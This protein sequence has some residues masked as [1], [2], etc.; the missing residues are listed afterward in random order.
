[1][2]GDLKLVGIRPNNEQEWG[3]YPT[4]LMKRALNQKPGLFGVQYSSLEHQ[5]F[6]RHIELLNQYLSDWE[7]EPELTDK[8]YLKRIISNILKGKI[9]SS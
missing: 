2:N 3:K 8:I 4:S 5:G 7:R 9:R 6:E 1:M